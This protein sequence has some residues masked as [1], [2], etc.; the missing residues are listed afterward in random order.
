M[1]TELIRTQM[2]EDGRAEVVRSME[3]KLG[4]SMKPWH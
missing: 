2:V 4:G 1:V 3:V